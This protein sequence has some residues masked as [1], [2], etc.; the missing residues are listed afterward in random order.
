MVYL[1]AAI[2]LYLMILKHINHDL[3]RTTQPSSHFEWVVGWA[4]L[5]ISK[6]FFMQHVLSMSGTEWIEYYIEAYTKMNR[7]NNNIC[8]YDLL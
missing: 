6:H 7:V 1:Q 3:S 4:I 5:F 8:S 2:I